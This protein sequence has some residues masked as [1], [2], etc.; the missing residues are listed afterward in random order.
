MSPTLKVR[1]RKTDK[2]FGPDRGSQSHYIK[3]IP[4]RKRSTNPDHT[5]ATF[6]IFLNNEKSYA[7]TLRFIQHNANIE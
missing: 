6:I 1:L 4:S 5:A 7:S 2:N 3:I